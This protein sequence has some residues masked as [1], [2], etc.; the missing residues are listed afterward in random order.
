MSRAVRRAYR[1]SIAADVKAAIIR[2]AGEDGDP[3]PPP[4]FL[5][6]VAADLGWKK[7]K[8]SRFLNSAWLLLWWTKKKKE[9]GRRRQRVRRRRWEAR[10]AERELRG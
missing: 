1:K 2:H 3:P 8:L 7:P 5:A 6:D 9:I 4:G 10:R